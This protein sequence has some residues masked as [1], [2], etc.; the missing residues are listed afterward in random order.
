MQTPQRT[1]MRRTS[2]IR[3]INPRL[4]RHILTY[5][6]WYDPVTIERAR[7]DLKQIH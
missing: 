4:S 7:E 6:Q 1:V 5:S 2:Q 3:S